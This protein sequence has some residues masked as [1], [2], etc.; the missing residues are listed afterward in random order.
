MTTKK[1]VRAGNRVAIAKEPP[2][3]FQIMPWGRFVSNGV[4]GLEIPS[5]A[6][7]Q[8]LQLIVAADEARGVDIPI[9]FDHQT[10][11]PA[12]LATGKPPLILGYIQSFEAVPGDG[13]YAT[14][15]TWTPPGAELV[16]N[17]QL[18]YPSFYGFIRLSDNRVEEITSVCLTSKPF[19]A[20]VKPVVNKQPPSGRKG[21]DMSQ[22]AKTLGL[23]DGAD[24]AAV[25]NAI[26]TLK[27][28]A[29]AGVALRKSV[30][31]AVSLDPAKTVKDDEVVAAINAARKPAEGMVPRAEFDAVANS[32]K[33]TQE[34][35]AGIE[36][37]TV[38]RDAETRV[39]NAK[40]AGKLTDAMLQPDANGKNHWRSL[41]RNKADW[42]ACMERMPVVAPPEGRVVG[43]NA[44]PA[45]G[46]DR[47]AVINKA[48][49][50]YDTD[51]DL[52][53]LCNRDGYVADAL[54]TA[55]LNPKLSDD[56][57]KRVA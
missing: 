15:V 13:I 2:D 1:N 20:G 5:L 47:A 19:V 48:V 26:N 35:L 17:G 28:T 11:D 44:A 14:G 29:D 38:D 23:P 50:E 27:Q 52:R 34:R 16:R 9:D 8:S 55:G 56:E 12:F 57:K 39:A 21:L 33:T 51:G 46:S 40:S 32:L 22:I 41:A 24:E 54:R 30:C 31:N 18:R 25:V 36:K 43:N 42:D 6:D 49:A 45:G 3:R 4:D 10:E 37:E 7:E 53:K